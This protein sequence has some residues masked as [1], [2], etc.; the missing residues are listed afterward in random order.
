M[1]TATLPAVRTT[2][3]T[4]QLIESVLRE[5][6]TL[7]MF[8]EETARKHAQWRKEDDAFYAQ[9]LRRSA[10]LKAGKT[11]AIPFD[12]VMKDLRAMVA[13]KKQEQSAKRAVKAGSKAAMREPA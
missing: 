7:S 4:R 3:E 5:G 10:D 13:C 6:E 11:K 2:P 12:E 1:R 9:A 8:I